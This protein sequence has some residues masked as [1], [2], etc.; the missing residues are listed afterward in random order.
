MIT[1]TEVGTIGEGSERLGSQYVLFNSCISRCVKYSHFV[2][3]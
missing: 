2:Y 1:V 3:F